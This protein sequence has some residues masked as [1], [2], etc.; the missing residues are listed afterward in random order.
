MNWY[1]LKLSAYED[2]IVRHL[3]D[4]GVDTNKTHVYVDPTSNMATFPVYD[5]NGRMVGYQQ[6]NPLGDKK[7][8]KGVDPKDLKYFSYLS[9]EFKRNGVWGLESLGRADRFMFVTEGIFDAVKIHNAGYPAIAVMG[10]AGTNELKAQMQFWPYSI[11]ILDND[12][13]QAGNLLA[14]MTDTSFMTPDPYNDL[15]DMPQEEVNLFI[16]GIVRQL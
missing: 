1:K 7:Q 16:Q 8:R 5:N 15:G 6:Y 3:K 10:N 11:A 12:E 9:E 4:R 14:K 13:N 2:D